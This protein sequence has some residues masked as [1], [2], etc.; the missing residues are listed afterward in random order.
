MPDPL[1]SIDLT[2][3]DSELLLRVVKG[4]EAA[5]QFVYEKYSPQVF[6]TLRKYITD[7]EECK[8]LLQQIFITLW[9]KRALLAE[10]QSLDRYL[11]TTTR[12]KV[13]RHFNI[14]QKQVRLTGELLANQPA[15]GDNQHSLELQ[16]CLKWWQVA[17]D[18]LTTQ[19]KQVYTLVELHQVTLDEAAAHMHISK[20]TLKK[21]L[22][23]ARKAVRSS[24][25]RYLASPDFPVEV[26]VLAVCTGFFS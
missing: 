5:F 12:N 18:Q 21:H 4:E 13:F 10:V 2:D 7:A 25:S 9:E 15:A 8:E 26:L 19:Q 24:M 1:L 17:I 22:E 6:T 3:S 20:A 14:L 16:E 11:F 23:L